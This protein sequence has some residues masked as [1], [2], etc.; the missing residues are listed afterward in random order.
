[1]TDNT[2]ADPCREALTLFVK[3][4][5][6]VSTDIDP[7]GHRWSEAYLDQALAAAERALAQEPKDPPEAHPVKDGIGYDSRDLHVYAERR[8]A[9]AL[10]QEPAGRGAIERSKR[11]LALVD[12][13]HE[14]P[15]NGTRYTLRCALMDEFSAPQE[16]NPPGSLDSS[17][18]P[19][20]STEHEPTRVWAPVGADSGMRVLELCD[21]TGGATDCAPDAPQPP[22]ASQ[23]PAGWREHVEQRIRTWRQRAMN[24]SGDRLAID[25]FMGQESID[26][27]VDF[28]CDEWAQPPAASPPET[29]QDYH[30]W[31]SI[32]FTLMGFASG[33]YAEGLQDMPGWLYGLAE[34]IAREHVDESHAARA[35]EVGVQ[36]RAKYGDPHGDPLSADGKRPAAAADGISERASGGGQQ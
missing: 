14:R 32:V 23:E 2:P 17:Q 9:E 18:E 7:R 13:Y 26:D 33:L 16:P 1:M 10:A 21:M 11:I 36:M 12:D 27:L 28:V 22:A 8:V 31:Q 35:R 30:D 19:A 24:T 6:P 34:R 15:S 4:A 3:A 20:T 5:Y 25:D 29:A